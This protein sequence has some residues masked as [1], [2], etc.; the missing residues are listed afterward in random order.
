MR[1][2]T[3]LLMLFLACFGVAQAQT[4]LKPE[5]STAT[6]TYEYYLMNY[7]D[8]AYFATTTAGLAGGAQQLGSA[9][10]F[11]DTKAKVT[12][13]LTADNKL[14]STNTGTEL[15]LGYTTTGEAANSVQLFAADSQDGYTWNI[16]TSTNGGYTLSAGDGNNSW[17]M[18]GGAG[19]NIGL[20]RKT[21][22]GSNWVFVPANAAAE[23]KAA[24]LKAQYALSTEYYYQIQN[25]AYSTMLAANAN[26][27]IVT[28]TNSTSDL[29]QL[30]ALEQG[31]D[32]AFYLR[33]AGQE[34][35]LGHSETGNTAWPVVDAENKTAFIVDITNLEDKKY[36]IKYVGG[37]GYSCAH[38]ANWG[39][40][41]NYEQVVR[42]LASA[43][44]SQ[45]TFIKTS[46]PANVQE[47]TFTYSFKYKGVEK[48]TQTC[49]GL[50]GAAYPDVD[51]S[52]LPYG[53]AINK[54]AG[55]VTAEIA[56]TTV[57]VEVTDNLPFVAA[58]DYASINN[59]YYIQMHSN[60][61]YTKYIQAVEGFIEWAD[62]TVNASEIDSYTWG[63]IGNPFDGFKLVNYANG[64]TKGVN[65]TGSDNPAMGNIATA[66]AWTLK[67]SATNPTAEY[68]CFQYPGSANYMNAQGGKI[69][70][71]GSADNGSTMWVTE[72]DFSGATEL[73][74]VIDQVE[75][76]VA[77]G[78]NAG[79][80]VGYITS[81]S[82]TNVATALQAA[83]DAVVSKTGCL[84]AQTALQAA[85]DA[86]ETIQPEE[87]KFYAIQNILTGKYMNVANGAGLKVSDAVAMG[88]VFTFEAGQNGT[89]Y[90]KNVERGS[91]VNTALPHGWGQNT[92]AAANTQDAKVVTISNLGKNNQVSIV[93]NGGATLH[94]DTNYGNVVAWDGGADSK[95]AWVISE[96]NIEDYAHSV[97][98]TEAG[99][100]TLVLG[101]NATIPADV[102]VY[103]VSALST[104]TATLTE[105]QNV[106]PA[107]EA[108]LVNAP[109]E[110]YEFKYT[111]GAL[112][113]EGENLLEG[114]VFD[115]NINEDAYVLG[116]VNE[117]VG[118]YKAAKNVDENTAFLNNAFKAYLPKTNLNGANALRFNFGETTGI[119]S[120]VESTNANAVIFDLSGRRV[121]K[122]QKGIYIVNGKKVY[123]K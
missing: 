33:N 103:A 110:T 11:D 120:V 2:I 91:Y 53:V 99:W 113:L 44:A 123:V 8:Q 46:I 49:T 86:V 47:V 114:T 75:A 117:E 39:A 19:E 67:P 107:N 16:E 23:A 98:V 30:W 50:V 111:G 17:N 62:A 66:T 95:S 6:G 71:W 121:A 83:K 36:F 20:Y 105:V 84:E 10:A 25:K 82:V 15:I 78:V 79:T 72:R 68:F 92:A 22:G 74:A 60:P 9:N 69:A 104:E 70:F 87:G 109:A 94:H 56:G 116:I 54:P 57:D 41:Y 108:V 64:E 29:N 102:T 31:E 37:D 52:V 65:S 96:V 1:K 101:Y 18:H 45:W 59:W 38:D 34:K 97:T 3:S 27:A 89:F 28:S 76:F 21:D 35:Y 63:F 90:M 77:A 5:V 24:E 14:Y 58:A 119:E 122:M 42:W 85:V 81:E 32:G 115:T 51:M 118:L 4:W 48:A 40:S 80:T 7:R 55:E 12:F 43:D 73:Q 93:P 88:N 26:K 112:G 13:K 61:Q 106:I 100:A